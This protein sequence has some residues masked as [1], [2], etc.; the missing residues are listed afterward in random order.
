MLCPTSP[1]PCLKNPARWFRVAV[2]PLLLLI[3]GLWVVLRCWI[4][5]AQVSRHPLES[6]LTADFQ[7]ELRRRGLLP[8]RSAESFD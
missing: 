7:Q 1:W 8:A 5:L 2:V 6:G 3:A 4:L